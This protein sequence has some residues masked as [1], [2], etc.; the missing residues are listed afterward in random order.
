[1]FP[2]DADGVFNGRISMR[3]ARAPE[4]FIRNLPMAPFLHH[5][6]LCVHGIRDSVPIYCPAA[7]RPPATE[8]LPG[9]NASFRSNATPGFIV[10]CPL[11]DGG[12]LRSK[13]N[14]LSSS[15]HRG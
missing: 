5:L 2:L 12:A 10:T 9:Y 14:R 11:N 13:R 15:P 8:A 3:Y 1:M 7:W 6:R 4:R